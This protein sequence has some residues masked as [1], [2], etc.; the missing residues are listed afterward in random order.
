[1]RRLLPVQLA[2]LTPTQLADQVDILGGLYTPQLIDRLKSKRML[3]WCITHPRNI[4]RANF[5]V[6]GHK[7]SFLN[8]FEYDIVE[9]RAVYAV[10]PHYFELDNTPGHED[11]KKNWRQSLVKAL[12]DRII[13]EQACASVS[14]SPPPDGTHPA[15]DETGV[16]GKGD[17]QAAAEMPSNQ[18]VTHGTEAQVGISALT[19]DEARH[20]DYFYP[21]ADQIQQTRDKWAKSE[22]IINDLAVTLPGLRARAQEVKLEYDRVTVESREAS[23][24]A[25]LGRDVLK[26]WVKEAKEDSAAAAKALAQAEQRLQRLQEDFSKGDAHRKTTQAAFQRVEQHNLFGR[27]IAG[28]F[29][30]NP[31][32]VETKNAVKKLSDEEEALK[33]AAEIAELRKRRTSASNGLGNGHE[34]GPASP[35]QAGGSTRRKSVSSRGRTS[36]KGSDSGGKHHR[37][38][39]IGAVEVKG[40][41]GSVHSRPGAG[42]ILAMLE[43]TL[44]G[45]STGAAGGGRAGGFTIKKPAAATTATGEGSE[46]CRCWWWCR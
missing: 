38:G 3:H 7:A 33:R 14:A 29:D 26:A 25:E 41:K 32:L 30:E 36:S 5:L 24:R 23:L 28:V 45:P 1:M 9:L 31:E 44:G 43:K 15:A 13:R 8:L 16:G 39:S 20:S 27:P 37:S 34:Q 6:G 21:T 35:N 40:A 10:C 2:S 19:A 42:N 11:E 18:H 4:A 17:Q 22:A 12:K 46:C